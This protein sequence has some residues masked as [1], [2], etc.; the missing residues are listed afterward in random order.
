LDLI[1]SAGLLLFAGA[2]AL[3]KWRFDSDH[4]SDIISLL[5][6]MH[7]LHELIALQSFLAALGA[8]A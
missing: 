6:L 1:G 4:P 2:T 7:R 8:E 5:R 3:Q